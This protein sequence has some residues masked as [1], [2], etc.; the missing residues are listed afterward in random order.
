MSEVKNHLAGY[1]ESKG[2]TVAECQREAPKTVPA[3]YLQRY[4]DST[5]DEY[6]A[7]IHDFLNGI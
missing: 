4:P 7:D 1:I 6:L 2:F 3:F 5:Y